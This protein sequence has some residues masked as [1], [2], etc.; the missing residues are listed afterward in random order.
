MIEKTYT[1]KK[2]NFIVNITFNYAC[3]DV[4]RRRDIA[5]VILYCIS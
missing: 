4:I 2:E 5:I 3:F 1:S